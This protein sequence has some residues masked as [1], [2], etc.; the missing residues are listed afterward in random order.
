LNWLHTVS[1]PS[2][3]YYTVHPRRGDE[4]LLDAG[5]LPNCWGWVVHDGF[6][7][8]FSFETIRHALCNAHH[9]RELTFLVEQY[10]VQTAQAMLDLLLTMKDHSG[11]PSLV[12]R[13]RG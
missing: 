11:S 6:K 9:L 1:T 7:P 2:L 10:G 13:G 4:A 5:V 12:C 8:Y 3:T